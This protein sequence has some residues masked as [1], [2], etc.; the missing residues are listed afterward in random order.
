MI[1]VGVTCI[2]INSQVAFVGYHG[3]VGAAAVAGLAADDGNFTQRVVGGVDGLQLAAVAHF[4]FRALNAAK[5]K[6]RQR[7][8][9]RPTGRRDRTTTYIVQN[10]G[11][12]NQ[13]G[14]V[15]GSIAVSGVD[16]RSRR[17]RSAGSVVL[18]RRRVPKSRYRK[19]RSE[20]LLPVTR[21]LE[22][23]SLMVKVLPRQHVYTYG[24]EPVRSDT[25]LHRYQQRQ[26]QQFLSS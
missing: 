9:H 16:V 15:A 13:F 2:A 10:D 7:P 18:A 8:G 21:L 12:S 3:V 26:Q 5:W 24:A 1:T 11:R 4:D 23:G 25:E 22:V 6:F 17:N 14:Y 19:N 20:Q